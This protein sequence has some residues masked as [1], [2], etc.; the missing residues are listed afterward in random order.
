MIIKLNVTTTGSAG[1][2]TGTATSE[3]F[4]GRIEAVH[5]DFNA[6]APATTDTTIALDAPI[7]QTLTTLTN[8]ATDVTL[9]PSYALTDGTG[10]GRT[11]YEK[12]FA[13]WQTCTVT[14]AQSDALTD[15]VTVYLS[16]SNYGGR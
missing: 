9:Y 8:T 1:S 11:Q 2:A 16:I 15:A 4:R 12:F 10:A 5:V 7:A 13:D 3:R 6:S 14:V